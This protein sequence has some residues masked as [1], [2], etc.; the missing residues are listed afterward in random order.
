ML[1]LVFLYLLLP[2]L[3]L[4]VGAVVLGGMWLIGVPG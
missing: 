1:N 3:A 4:I 2:I